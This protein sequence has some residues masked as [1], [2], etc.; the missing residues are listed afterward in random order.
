MGI[1]LFIK[2]IIIRYSGVKSME[3][4]NIEDKILSKLDEIAERING[5]SLAEYKKMIE[6]P[7]RMILINFISGLARGLGIAIGATV[8]AAIFLIFLFKIAQ[9]NLPIIGA[10]IARIVKIVQTYL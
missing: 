10:F 4:K 1:K 9:L 3:N 7:R 8:L 5:I 2:G 6:S